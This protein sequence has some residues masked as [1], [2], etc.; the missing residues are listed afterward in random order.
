MN[1][2]QII[3]L[4]HETIHNKKASKLTGLDK[5]N[6]YNYR[7]RETSLGTKLELLIR[8]NLITITKNEPEGPTE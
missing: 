5:A 1:E 3:E 8:M 4:F 6:L 7:H 2:Q